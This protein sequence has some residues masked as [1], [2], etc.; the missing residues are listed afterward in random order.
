M[1]SEYFFIV[2]S[3]KDPLEQEGLHGHNTTTMLIIL[4]K[5]LLHF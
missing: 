4:Q 5:N 3:L 2:H 1:K